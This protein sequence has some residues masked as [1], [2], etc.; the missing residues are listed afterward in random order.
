MI[1]DQAMVEV[2]NG[3]YRLFMVGNG[4]ELLDIMVPIA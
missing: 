3:S 2:N 1:N 4:F